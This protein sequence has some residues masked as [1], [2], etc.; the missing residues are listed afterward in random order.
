MLKKLNITIP[1][2]TLGFGIF[3]ISY[4]KL[5][6]ENTTLDISLFNITDNKSIKEICNDFD[7]D[8][9]YISKLLAKP[10]HTDTCN[11]IIWHP[12]TIVD[13][14]LPGKNIGFTHFETT[15]FQPEVLANMQLDTIDRILVTNDWAK[16]TLEKYGVCSGTIPGP[17][18]PLYLNTKESDL[19]LDFHQVNE[20]LFLS[21]GKWEIRKGHHLLVEAFSKLTQKATLIGIWDN[22]FLGGST[23]AMVFIQANGF[24]L[25]TY[26]KVINNSLGYVYENK[27]GNRII[28]ITRLMNSSDMV[29]FYKYVDCYINASAGEGWNLP[30]VEAMS[31]GTPVI[32]TNNTAHAEYITKDNSFVLNT[33]KKEIAKDGIWF[34]GDVGSW[35][36]TNVPDLLTTMEHVCI[37][38]SS[39]LSSIGQKGQL[40][41]KDLCSPTN[42]IKKLFKFLS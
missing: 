20:T 18:L 21:S 29:Y 19:S 3:S 15:N 41:I 5:L 8:E 14:L 11:L 7:I 26:I 1:I 39:T 36:P 6:I 27:I 13:F 17:A 38:K 10:A 25:K 4:L 2:N 30:L 42:I 28:V 33:S 35:Y 34:K 22:V 31:V 9:K 32:S 40:T 24:L 23:P 12:G 16:S 37:A